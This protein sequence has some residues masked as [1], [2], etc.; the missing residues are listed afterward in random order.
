MFREE[1]R[2][3]SAYTQE[4]L[5]NKSF[6]NIDKGILEGL[7]PTGVYILGATSK[8]GKTMIATAL[9]NAVATG[10]EYLG[11]KN[12]QAKVLYYDNDNYEYEAT[13][14]LRALGMG[15]TSNI[16]YVFG[17]EAQSIREIKT[18]IEYCVSDIQDYSLVII[19]CF[20]GLNEFLT[21]EDNYKNIYKILKEFRDFIIEKNLC[22][23]VLHHI[24]KGTATGQD[25]LLGTK[26]LSGATT[27]TII[28]NVN[29]EFATE[30]RLEFMLRH[31]KEVIPIKKDENGI[32]WVLS[33][34]EV[35]S[36]EIDKNLLHL[37]NTVVS[38]KEKE[39]TGTVQEIIQKTRME[40]N[41]YGLHKYLVKNK[42]ILNQNH[43]TFERQRTHD[44]R[45]VILKYTG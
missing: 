33:T 22:C 17:E 32:G 14:R 3:M 28:I 24:K 43:I 12:K 13:N 45:L 39:L 35:S 18:D 25:K 20:I 37:I 10:S 34:E 31:K 40:I 4:E 30:G 36:E 16:R 9:A 15:M 41:P 44:D 29:N 42:E 27:G 26:A 19:D 6:N 8:I 21:V 1:L 23:I 11:K 5:L 2:K 7:L 38:I